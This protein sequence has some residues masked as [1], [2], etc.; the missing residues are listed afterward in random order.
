MVIF[1][2]QIIN[3]LQINR[4]VTLYMFIYEIGSRLFS[5]CPSVRV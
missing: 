3:T 1:N 5:G 2:E 4:Y